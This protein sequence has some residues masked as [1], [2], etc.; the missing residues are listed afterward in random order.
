M[1]G[2]CGGF[3]CVCVCGGGGGVSTFKNSPSHHK[4]K[5][6]KKFLRIAYLETIELKDLKEHNCNLALPVFPVFEDKK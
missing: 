5:S 2:C 3:V 6:M 4:Y 1:G